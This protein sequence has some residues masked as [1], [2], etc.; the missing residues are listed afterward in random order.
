[1]RRIHRLILASLLAVLVTAQALAQTPVAQEPL[2]RTAFAQA[3]T[4]SLT[5]MQRQ[6]LGQHALRPWLE[7]LNLKAQ[8]ATIGAAQVLEVIR[9]YPDSASTEWLTG[10][11]R[12]ELLRRQDWAG[13]GQW[14]TLY[15]SESSAVRCGLLLAVEP[16]QRML[17]WRQN[18]LALWVNESQLP[19][20]CT[21]VFDFL[22][23]SAAID[24][25]SA[26]QRF[27]RL[28][29]D[30]AFDRIPEVISQLGSDSALA[31][32]YRSFLGSGT[33]STG[34]WPDT[35]RSRRVLQKGL[36]ALAK[37]SPDQAEQALAALPATPVLAAE[38][39]QAV[40][41]EIA[42][43][44]L[45]NYLPD[46]ERR[47][48]AVAEAARTANLRE[49][50]M[51]FAFSRDDNNK[52]LA[53]FDQLLPAQQQ[54][55][56][57]QYFKARILERLGNSAQA[58]ALYRRAARSANYHGW[59]A[60]DRSQS[61][62]ALCPLEPMPSAKENADLLRNAGL[63]RALLLWQLNQANTAIWEWN[64]AYKTLSTEQQRK[65]VLLA[66][67][68]GWYDRAV[69]ALAGQE[70]SSRLYSLRFP[71]PYLPA[72][73]Q[74]ASR[75]ALNASWLMA[76]A[77]AESIFMPDV[78]S[79]ANARGLLQVI[80]STA[81]TIALRNQ[82]PWLGADS[83][84]LPEVNIPLGAGAL[85]DAIDT[86]NGKAYQAIAAYNAGPSAVN[87]W[88]AARGNLDP[89]FWVETIPY[90]ETREYVPRVL[91][92]SVIFDWRRNQAV[93]PI[94]NRLNGDFNAK[95][96]P[97]ALRCP[98]IGTAETETP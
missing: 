58:Q 69:F 2:L 4:G 25:G 62:Y 74:A 39:R 96:R 61:A 52:T 88:L 97:V 16:S 19:A 82:I 24:A 72:F 55:D 53:A 38:Q 60:A 21:A 26:W 33:G 49:W 68:V 34:D 89:D 40:L 12:N 41:S 73:E 9:Q 23:Q 43:W 45:V 13:L 18:A 3:R 15:P 20:P 91:A 51:R 47:F 90:K 29:L 54:E 83:L 10:Q 67:S 48:F 50:Y 35:V 75:F 77:R 76:H 57:W 46:A 78:V 32:R 56:R 86:Y 64:A 92:F 27:D 44:S 11:W 85:R 66:Q 30:D 1:M 95:P 80:P 31:E 94:S 93:V 22:K 98:A 8:I 84:Y 71:T 81:E 17:A 36:S 7:A 42:L 59:L 5:D 28:L 63:Q 70:N 6:Q 37:R 14:Q 79:G 65:A 87:R